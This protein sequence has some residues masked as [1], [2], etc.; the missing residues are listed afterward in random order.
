MSF[1]TQTVTAKVSVA[2]SVFITNATA[3]LAAT[4]YSHVLQ[5]NLKQLTVKARGSSKLQVA[6]VSGDSS[7]N[8]ISIPKGAVLNMDTIDFSA[9]TLYFQSSNASEIIEILEL[10]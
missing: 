1:S 7:L 6:F 4:E 5:D 10:V 3:T 2:K 9:T 8:Y